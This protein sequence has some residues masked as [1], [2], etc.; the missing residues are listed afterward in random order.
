MSIH[1]QAIS[2][3]DG[4]QIIRIFNHY[5]ENS[6]AAFREKKVDDDFIGHLLSDSKDYPAYVVCDGDEILGFGMLRP[7]HPLPAFRRTADVMYF[8]KPGHTGQGLGGLLLE[9]L[10]ADA[11]NMN[12]DSILACIVSKNEGSV[13]FHQRHGF[14]ECGRIHNAGRKFGVDFDLIWMQ[15]HLGQE[16]RMLR[17]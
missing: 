13:R 2:E 9:R 6:F 17:D 16:G 7:F 12:I 11:Q 8:L 1:L 4:A 15:K 14:L 10:I 3:K 5:V